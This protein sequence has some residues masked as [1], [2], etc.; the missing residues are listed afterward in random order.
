MTDILTSVTAV[1]F[2]GDSNSAHP[3]AASAAVGTFNQI[4][5]VDVSALAAEWQVR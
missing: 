1:W 5:K 2:V 3:F 4:G